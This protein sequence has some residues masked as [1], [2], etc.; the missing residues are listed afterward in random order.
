[1]TT[2]PHLRFSFTYIYLVDLYGLVHSDNFTIM[3]KTENSCI[4]Y[5]CD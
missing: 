4:S 2:I 5:S 1:M 3:F